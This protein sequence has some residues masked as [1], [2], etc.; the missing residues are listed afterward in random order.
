MIIHWVKVIIHS[1][2]KFCNYLFILMSIQKP[3]KM[4]YWTYYYTAITYLEKLC[5][6]TIIHKNRERKKESH[7][8][9]LEWHED[10][11]INFHGWNVLII[12]FLGVLRQFT[13][14]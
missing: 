1:K 14:M 6:V 9:G 5:L 11:L 13:L 12:N 2:I 7:P 8:K 3:Y 10:D 4:L